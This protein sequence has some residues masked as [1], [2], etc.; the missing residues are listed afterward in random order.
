MAFYHLGST[1]LPSEKVKLKEDLHAWYQGLGYD[2]G[3]GPSEVLSIHQKKRC[4][5]THAI[6]S[7]S[8]DFKR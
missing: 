2:E 6:F 5:D 3:F 7:T 4:I 8:D 1:F